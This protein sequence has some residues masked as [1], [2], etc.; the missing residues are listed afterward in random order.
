MRHINRLFFDIILKCLVTLGNTKQCQQRLLQP[1]MPNQITSDGVSCEGPS[2][3]GSSGNK[4]ES[5]IDFKG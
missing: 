2:G 5:V 4:N 3:F 1:V